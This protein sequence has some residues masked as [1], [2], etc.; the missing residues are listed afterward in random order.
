M[1]FLMR[2]NLRVLLPVVLA[3]VVAACAMPEKPPMVIKLGVAGEYVGKVIGPIQRGQ[4]GEGAG[5]K[6]FE[7]ELPSPVSIDDKSDCG[8]QNVAS[9]PIEK[10]G[11]APFVGKTVHL[12]ATAYCRSD[13]TGAYHLRDVTVH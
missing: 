5:F 12:Q 6:S 8:P 7:L 2:F 1:K 13:R 10:D 11:M 3:V 9:L 4:P